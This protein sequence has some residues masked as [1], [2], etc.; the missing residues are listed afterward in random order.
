MDALPREASR[1]CRSG[2]ARWLGRPEGGDQATRPGPRAS[3]GTVASLGLPL[4][5]R[6]PP[7]R[8]PLNQEGVREETRGGATVRRVCAT[9]TSRLS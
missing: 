9:P 7:D 5:Y 4:R 3:R 8:R 6:R 1:P 2:F